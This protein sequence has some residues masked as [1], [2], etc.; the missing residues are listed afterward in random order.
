MVLVNPRKTYLTYQF[1][2]FCEDNNIILYRLPREIACIAQPLDGKPLQRYKH[3][4]TE[5]VNETTTTTTRP[6]TQKFTNEDFLTALPRIRSN[7]VDPD[8]IRSAFQE[9]SIHP[10]NPTPVVQELR[11]VHEEKAPEIL[12]DDDDDEPRAERNRTPSRSP[13]PTIPSELAPTPK[14]RRQM[15]RM[16]LKLRRLMDTH[17]PFEFVD[18]PWYFDCIKKI[19]RSNEITDIISGLYEEDLERMRREEEEEG[20]E[21]EGGE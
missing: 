20:A 14:S 4:Y 16:I 19:M 18:S 1:I 11:R 6:R 8:T 12:T 2:K 3:F 7:A 15:R 17:S 5:A 9:R 13:S 21:G 10:F